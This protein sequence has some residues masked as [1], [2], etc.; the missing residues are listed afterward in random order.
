MSLRQINCPSFILFI[1]SSKCVSV[2]IR[3]VQKDDNPHPFKTNKDE[4]DRQMKQNG[5]HQRTTI[6]SE[7]LSLALELII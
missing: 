3:K 5:D 1:T 2:T 4:E 6:P 7:G